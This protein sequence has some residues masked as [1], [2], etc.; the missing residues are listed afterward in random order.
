MPA[1][2]LFCAIWIRHGPPCPGHAWLQI[3]KRIDA[4]QAPTQQ[5]QQHAADASQD[6]RGSGSTPGDSDEMPAAWDAQEEDE[7]LAPAHRYLPPRPRRHWHQHKGQ[8]QTPAEESHDREEQGQG[9]EQGWPAGGPAAEDSSDSEWGLRSG[10]QTPEFGAPTQPAAQ[11][12]QQQQQGTAAGGGLMVAVVN[13]LFGSSRPGTAQGMQAMHGMLPPK[14]SLAPGR[15]RTSSQAEPASSSAMQHSLPRHSPHLSS[16]RMHSL[17]S[18]GS[19]FSGKP[20][21]PPLMDMQAAIWPG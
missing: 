10:R 2:R 8:Q 7:V 1:L 5:Q 3:K 11:L 12:Q 13:P 9:P 15:R 4:Q 19:G 6:T 18:M 14:R 21:P 16:G 20:R 17:G